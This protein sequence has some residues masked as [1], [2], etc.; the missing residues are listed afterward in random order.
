MGL[1]G[2]IHYPGQAS[3]DIGPWPIDLELGVRVCADDMGRVP[4]I[5]TTFLQA[6]N[7]QENTCY[8]FEEKNLV[9]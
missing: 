1:A 9:S 7:L 5:A 4:Q 3:K 2:L 8:I 6:V